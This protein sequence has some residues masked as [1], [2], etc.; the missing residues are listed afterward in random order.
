MITQLQLINI[1]I[2]I[3]IYFREV[4]ETIVIWCGLSEEQRTICI[5]VGDVCM[6]KQF[7]SFHLHLYNSL[8]KSNICGKT[9]LGMRCMISFY[10]QFDF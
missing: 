9:L 2:I 7:C 3:K 8:Q 10:L 1:I 6:E 4:L 5:N